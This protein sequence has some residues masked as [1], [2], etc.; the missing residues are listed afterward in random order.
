MLFAWYLTIA[1]KDAIMTPKSRINK[2]DELIKL[3]GSIC[4]WCCK[5]LKRDEITVEHLLPKSYNGSDALDNLFLACKSCNNS[6]GN[7]LVP[8]KY[9]PQSIGNQ[10]IL[11]CLKTTKHLPCKKLN[12]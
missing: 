4:C 11:E 5:Q 3:Y 10:K 6:R 9:S 2:I 12:E 8:P 1:K 7:R